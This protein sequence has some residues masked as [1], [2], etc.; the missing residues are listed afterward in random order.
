MNNRILN[1]GFLS[2]LLLF[3][4]FNSLYSSEPNNPKSN[5]GTKFV[6]TKSTEMPLTARVENDTVMTNNIVS[7]WNNNDAYNV[8]VAL[9]DKDSEIDIGIYNMLGK[10]VLKVV[11]K[12]VQTSDEAIYEFNVS[13]LPNGVYLCVLIGRN[14]RDVEKF[15]IS[16]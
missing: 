15:I 4:L 10:E 9:K 12:G 1:L 8:K 11:Q 3:S 6:D 5:R 7:V 13:K 16:R 14:F 2:I